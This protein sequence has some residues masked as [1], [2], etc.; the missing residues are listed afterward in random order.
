MSTKTYQKVCIFGK[1]YLSLCI[2]KKYKQTEIGIDMDRCFE[3]NY[4]YVNVKPND[5]TH[6]MVHRIHYHHCDEDTAIKYA[7]DY[8]KMNNLNSTEKDLLEFEYIY[9]LDTETK[10]Y[11]RLK[12]IL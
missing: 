10:L 4:K 5:F 12:R 3:I 11:S 1:F 7:K 2:V 6:S 9:E 8:L